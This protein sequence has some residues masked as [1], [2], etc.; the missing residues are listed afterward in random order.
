MLIETMK[1]VAEPRITDE[2]LFLAISH[3][4][5][6]SKIVEGLDPNLD[7]MKHL[8]WLSTLFVESRH[9]IIFEGALLFLSNCIRRLYMSQF[10]NESEVSL[11]TTLL[12]E[13]KFADTFLRKMEH[14]SDIVWNEDNFTHILVSIINKGLSNPFI[15]STAFD[16]LKM[17]FRNSYFEHQIDP[18]SDHYLC[19]MFLLYFI[20]SSSQFGELLGDVDFEGEM[21]TIE[22]KNTIPKILSEWLS[23]DKEDANITLYQ[24]ALLFKCAVTDEP[25]KFRFA[26]IIRHLL[27]VRPICCLLYTSRCV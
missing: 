13:R 18:K 3:I 23:S 21:V 20:L 24:G 12:K 15:K 9:P 8:F 17:M 19:Y 2:H 14:L 6:Y 26:L 1:V 10:E 5:T 16:F 27:K 22:N 25:S 11:I 7:L 4:F